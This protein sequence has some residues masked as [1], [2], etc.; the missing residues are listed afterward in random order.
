MCP[1]CGTPLN[2][3]DAPQATQQR[4]FIRREIARCATKDE[5]KDRLVGQYGQ[6]VLALPEDEGFGRAAYLVPLGALV[7]ALAAVLLALRR[8][9]RTRPTTGPDPGD[10]LRENVAPDAPAPTPT[11]GEQRRLDEDLAR[12]DL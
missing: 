6:A 12:Y 9:R 8:W 1:V 2:T 4:N 10:A 11:Q 3:A 7:L 5:I